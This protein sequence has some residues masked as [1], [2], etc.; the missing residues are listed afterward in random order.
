MNIEPK[1]KNERSY[2]LNTGMSKIK[3]L[4]KDFFKIK[5]RKTY[6]KIQVIKPWRLGYWIIHLYSCYWL[7][8]RSSSS[9][10]TIYLVLLLFL[11][12][13]QSRTAA[14]EI[15]IVRVDS[16]FS[17][18]QKRWRKTTTTT[19]ETKRR[20]EINKE[21]RKKANWRRRRRKSGRSLLPK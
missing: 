1:Q 6:S 9:S 12:F 13:R 11:L 20:R 2:L 17:R 4:L 14:C 19:K 8:S 21:K 7:L 16:Q 3:C 15:D 10:Y 5:M 18:Q